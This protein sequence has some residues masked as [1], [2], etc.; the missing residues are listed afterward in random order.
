MGIDCMQTMFLLNILSLQTGQGHPI[1]VDADVVAAR[2]QPHVE[3]LTH[4]CINAASASASTSIGFLSPV[5]SKSNFN[6][7]HVLYKEWVSM[8]I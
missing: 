7:K 4:G 8:L 2:T 6:N 5:W 3:I 1:V